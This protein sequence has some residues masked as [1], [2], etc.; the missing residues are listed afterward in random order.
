MQP[1]GRPN[2]T[3]YFDVNGVSRRIPKLAVRNR[4]NDI[5]GPD[6][7]AATSVSAPGSENANSAP[8]SSHSSHHTRTPPGERNLSNEALDLGQD[9][10]D[11][12]SSRSA[13]KFISYGQ[14]AKKRKGGNVLGFL[15]L[16][17]PSTSAWAEFAEAEKEKARQ[18]GGNG[19]NS[20]I[21]GVSP[22][23]LPG[24]VPKVNS[25]WDGLPES[26]NRKSIE[27]KST[28]KTN[29]NSTFST[30]TA[31]SNWTATSS[32]GSWAPKRP[33]GSRSNQPVQSA[34]RSNHSSTRSAAQSSTGGRTDSSGGSTR[35][36]PALALDVDAE[37]V[38]VTDENRPQTFLG[39]PSPPPQE[40]IY[41]PDLLP[42]L[43]PPE[44]EGDD[45]LHLLELD[46]RKSDSGPTSP[47]TPATDGSESK[48]AL[49]G[50]HYPELDSLEHEAT[51][52]SSMVSWLNDGTESTDETKSPS[53]QRS[54]RA[55][56][57]SRP[58]LRKPN[59]PALQDIP[60]PK[61]NT[62]AGRLSAAVNVELSPTLKDSA[63][64]I[65]PFL[66][67]TFASHS[68][69]TGHI[70]QRISSTI[71]KDT[72]QNAEGQSSPLSSTGADIAPLSPDKLDT[73]I[74]IKRSQSTRPASSVSTAT[75]LYNPESGTIRSRSEVSLASSTAPS[76]LSE[77]W[78]M[79]PKERL[80]LG[81]RVRRSEVMPWEVTKDLPNNAEGLRDDRL[82]T[83]P[84]S[85]NRSKR[86]S[87]RLS[88]KR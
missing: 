56:N 62:S 70:P 48:P 10:G 78:Q 23:K 47:T 73:P 37:P 41:I 83:P 30:A 17:E 19:T 79:S 38:E 21:S 31:Q 39:D 49:M 33:V 81:S 1:I 40:K 13:T 85:E 69:E 63:G 18:R 11:R 22:Q 32:V 61:L 24:F 4:V 36:P 8:S 45:I 29:R 72:K 6:D 75:A 52:A 88:L 77:H 54:R 12:G 20:G 87:W 28:N 3:N 68:R 2:S 9:F 58:R 55:I 34:L 5:E 74:V 65:D 25:K 67:D 57:F 14:G 59:L 71:V 51:P 53:P 44:L 86:L 76:E 35:Q 50:I 66:T 64:R 42:P 26:V 15:S 82:L 60:E 27:S 7:Q 43:S 84:L 80:G 16:K 46:T